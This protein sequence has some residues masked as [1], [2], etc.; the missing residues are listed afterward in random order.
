MKRDRDKQF[1]G[2]FASAF[3]VLAISVLLLVIGGTQLFY[4]QF[5]LLYFVRILGAL[6]CISGVWMSGSYFARQLYRRLS[7]YDF[8]AGILF[9]ISG[10]L[11]LIRAQEITKHVPLLLGALCLLIGVILLQ[12]ALQVRILK[13]KVWGFILVF[14]ILT[15]VSSVLLILNPGRILD[16][17]SMAL[18]IIL[19]VIGAGTLIAQLCAAYYT[20]RLRKDEQRKQDR[21]MEELDEMDR[22]PEETVVVPPSDVFG[23]ANM[24]PAAPEAVLAEPADLNMAEENR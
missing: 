2:S 23:A 18:Y 16:I 3:G 22:A 15:V 6:L 1:Q 12:N 14:S 10:I 5:Q 11:V 20:R 17:Y 7:N 9:V 21:N 19:M 8:S 13:G 4:P 24:R